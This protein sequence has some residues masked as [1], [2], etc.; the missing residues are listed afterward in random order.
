MAINE[1]KPTREELTEQGEALSNRLFGAT[2]GALDV[3]SVYLGW[4]LGLYT[5]L[6]ESATASQLAGRAGIA[7]RY[8]R[9]WLE[10]Q[11]VTGLLQV[12]DPAKSAEERSYTLPPGYRV[13]LT[14]AESPFYVTP[15]AQTLAVLMRALP[16]VEQAFRTGAG[17]PW[18]SYGREALESQGDFNRAWLLSSLGSDYLPKIGDIYSRLLADPP[19]RV[20][21]VACGLGWAA[22]ALALAFPKIE[23]DAFDADEES[24]AMAR[25]FAA[26]KGVFDRIRFRVADAAQI[27]SG[28][29]YDMALVVEAVHDLS[30]PVEVLEAVRKSLAPTGSLIVAD[31]RVAETFTAP[32]DEVE[33]FMYAASIFCCLPTGLSDEPSEATGT[34]MRPSTLKA[35]ANRA[36]FSRFEVL[37]LE[38]PL[39]RF[40]RMGP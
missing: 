34:V 1:K 12:D 5:A 28:G 22:I 15:A 32:G 38:H 14:D 2:L 31:E 8:A 25:K 6:D 30:Q 35:Y 21:D 9:E 37:D 40:Y 26:E 19:A 29:P 16:A 20:A 13:A 10:Q 11:A 17:V 18:S 7:E 4:R 39:L 24:I 36:G 33:R 27:S 3:M 23:I